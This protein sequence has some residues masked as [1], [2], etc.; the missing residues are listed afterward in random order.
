MPH[1]MRSA[2]AAAAA[3]LA[4][5]R[6]LTRNHVLVSFA[7]KTHDAHSTPRQRVITFAA[8][9]SVR[10]W[11]LRRTSSSSSS[12]W[13]SGYVLCTSAQC[14][15]RSANEFCAS[16]ARDRCICCCWPLEI[17]LWN[18]AQSARKRRALRNER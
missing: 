10:R 5:A 7:H 2:A 14:A 1:T 3:A 8:A 15:H 16:V 18:P 12:S 17:P 13:R 6:A 4:L 9:I 11:N